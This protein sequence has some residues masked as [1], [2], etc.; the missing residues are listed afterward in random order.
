MDITVFQKLLLPALPALIKDRISLALTITL[1][2]ICLSC[3]EPPHTD[4]GLH[5]GMSRVASLP[6]KLNEVSGMAS[7]GT[8]SVYVHNDS[9]DMPRFYE[10][11]PGTGALLRTIRIEGARH[12]DYE[13]LAEDEEYLYLGDFGNNR[14]RR[15]NLVIYKIAKED[16]AQSDAVTAE[17]IRFSYPD[18]TEFTA[19]NDHNFDCEA[20]I[21]IGDSLYLF[22][23]NRGDLAT[24]IY[25][26]PKEPGNYVAERIGRFDAQGLITGADYMRGER[27]V[28]ALLGYERRDGRYASYLWLFTD[29]EG[30]DF[31]SGS[32]TRIDLAPDLQT[33][34]VLFKPDDTMIIASEEEKGGRGGIFVFHYSEYLP[35]LSVAVEV[36]E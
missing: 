2:T 25:R 8:H 19:R 31:F 22:S 9:G 27:N 23:K 28:L 36:V 26:L 33:E 5:P 13:E 7:T 1:S 17:E 21:A 16:A 35:E 24:D 14:G 30:T 18:Q 20:M 12:Y 32:R 3:A 15:Q 34:S 11:D 29:F 10:I 4:D 6:P